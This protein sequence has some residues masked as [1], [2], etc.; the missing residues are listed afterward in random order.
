MNRE[1]LILIFCFLVMMG[2]S[3][4]ECDCSN[5]TDVS[6]LSVA[7][8]CPPDGCLYYE[9]YIYDCCNDTWLPVGEP[10][11]GKLPP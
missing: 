11:S 3:A 9:Y 10:K 2:A 8:F 1:V 6:R 7:M 4:M 5:A